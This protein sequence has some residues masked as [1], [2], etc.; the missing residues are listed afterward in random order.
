MWGRVGWEKVYGN[1]SA[2]F[3]YTPKTTLK[4]ELTGKVCDT[5]RIKEKG[6]EPVFGKEAG[7]REALGTQVCE[8][9]KALVGPA[10]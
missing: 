4:K 3:F 6:K 8:P 1:S 9:T 2:Q 5:Y 7:I 10:I